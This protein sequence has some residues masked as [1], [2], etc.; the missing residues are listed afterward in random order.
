M[1]DFVFD[2]LSLT[3]ILWAV[4]PLVLTSL[5][6]IIEVLIRGPGG[7]PDL[8]MVKIEFYVVSYR[9]DHSYQMLFTRSKNIVPISE[10]IA[11]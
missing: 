7:V 8:G 5:A 6:N 2:C 10:V 3:N 1:N 4:I 11:F 9:G